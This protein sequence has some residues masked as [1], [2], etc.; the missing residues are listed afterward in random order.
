VAQATPVPAGRTHRNRYI[1][2]GAAG[3]LVLFLAVTWVA[4]GF[5]AAARPSIAVK[6]GAWIDQGRFKLKVLNARAG[7]LG[8]GFSTK[9]NQLAV[10]MLVEN[11]S[12]ESATSLELQ[13]AIFASAKPGGPRNEV[14]DSTIIVAGGSES[15]FH[16]RI[17]TQI[18]IFWELPNGTSLPQ[19]IVSVRK[20]VFQR[21]PVGAAEPFWNLSKN[22]PVVATVTLPVRQGATS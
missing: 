8:A 6:P 4:G 18:D 5:D 1:A 7:V 19:A 20:S 14:T 16:P 12:D 15:Y 17:P 22:S 2:A 10:R 13:R 11:T 9:K 3:L 21:E